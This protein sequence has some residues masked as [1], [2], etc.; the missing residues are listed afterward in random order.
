MLNVAVIGAGPM[1]LATAHYLGLAGHRVTLYEKD[2]VIGGMTASFDFEGVDIERFYHFICGTDEP[3]F[4]LL[5]ELELEHQLRWVDTSMGYFHE[6]RLKDWGDPISLLRFPGLSLIAKIRYGLM[7]FAA[8]KRKNWKPLDGR[9][10]IS[11]LKKWVG[12]EAYDILWK[13]L[14]E[15]KFYQFT[16]NLSAAWV[17]S[18]M[19]RVGL[20]RRNLFQEQM[21]YLLGGSSTLLNGLQT[22]IEKNGN[23]I[24]LSKAVQE[25]CF[26]GSRA[27]GVRTE[28]GIERFE[29]VISTIPMPFVSE[30]LPSLP[31]EVTEKYDSLDNIAVVCVLI[32]LDRK[33]T[34]YFWLN[35]SD[36][37]IPM[38]GFI[39]YTNLYP[40]KKHILYAPFYMPADHADYARPNSWFESE[41]RRYL[42]MID[43]TLKSEEILSIRAG[44]YKFAQPICPPNF[45]DILPSIT[46]TGC[47]NVL[48]A[49]TSFYY[50]EDRSISES[51]KLGKR[52][53]KMLE[54]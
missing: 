19:R 23:R 52:L 54:E 42:G 28:D 50:P 9:D 35:I 17:W 16:N 8:T 25:I 6:G 36:P 30:L 47:S 29:R 15:L 12:D 5:R 33:L 22:S 41:V 18:R 10:A 34:D 26:E 39:E 49:D 51:V 1:G 14:F 53:A 32:K 2:S 20:S 3:Y 11:W 24:V 13:P 40:M 4:E 43:P 45:M 21:G 31:A 44:R 37:K 48:I 27:T 7:A 46:P 38:P